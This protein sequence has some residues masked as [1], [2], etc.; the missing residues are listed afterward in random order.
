MS[1]IN[2]SAEIERMPVG[3]LLLGGLA[4]L[5]V[6]V[7]IGLIFFYAPV[8]ALQ[9]EVFR[10]FYLHVPASWIGMLSFI[11]LAVCGIVYL[12]RP[13]ERLDWIA[14]AS[15]EIG[16]IFLTV[17][18]VM[19]SLWAKPIWGTWWAWDAK[20]TA[21]L[22]LWFMFLGYLMLRSYMGRT[23]ES[24]RAGAVW[25]IVGVIDVPII[26]LSVQW[27]RG[28]HP[29]PEVSASGGLPPEALLTLFVALFAFTLLYCFLMVQIYHLQR[30][31]TQANRLRAIVE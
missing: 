4:A 18:L 10:I 8:D 13:D 11:V 24:A 22:I 21:V 14:R 26:Y 7:S 16:A 30:L 23:S 12:I 5:S 2:H 20:L 17:G 19:G 31:Q 15:A 28:Q 3:S 1:A 9:G 27:W 25:A 29:G 6:L